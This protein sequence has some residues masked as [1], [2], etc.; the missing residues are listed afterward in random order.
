MATI[1]VQQL[2]QV[3]RKTRSPKHVFQLRT[4]PWQ[5]QPF[6]I[7]PVIPG[8]TLKNLLLQARV[9]T[10]PIKHPLI[11]WWAEYYFFY[12]K[13]R[14][15]DERDL[16]T[17]MVLD[18]TADLSSLDEAASSVYYHGGGINWTKLCLKRVVDQYF[19]NEGEA[20]DGFLIDNV[21]LA[22]AIGNEETGLDS[23]H[24]DADRASIDDPTALVVGADD[25]I[26]GSEI[27][28]ALRQ[29]QFAKANNLT[30]QT[31][32]EWLQTYG[33]RPS[34]VELHRPELVRYIR[35]W[36]YPSNT[37]DP[38]TGAPSSACSWSI[39]ERADKD[40]FIKEPGFLFGV[41]VVRPKVYMSKQSGSLA[42]LM[43][44]AYTW[45][46]AILH[47]DPSTSLVRRDA[48]AAPLDSNTDAYWVDVADL[49]HYGDQF[50]NFAL[51]ETDA[52]LVALPTA[53]L[54]KRYATAADADAL[55]VTP[56]SANQIRQDGV[57]SLN[58]ASRV[59]DHTPTI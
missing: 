11:G 17:Q 59:M 44:D 42:A 18:P 26:K 12:V 2:Q 37:V 27:E 21:P 58:I 14:D 43:N 52:G 39:A 8:D 28:T 33:I 57:V 24:N 49:L 31:Y 9:V 23:A 1:Q 48:L 51:T 6:M 7:A 45:L 29:W 55:F 38:A 5:I 40:R 16:L 4:K 25:S 32:E 34:S 19:R 10:D 53:G 13:H 35:D 15:L 50:L 20:W 46:P 36:T 54:Q 22:A 56:A 30:Q 47:D 41:S 3:S